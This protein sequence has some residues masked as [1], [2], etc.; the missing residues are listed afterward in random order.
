MP[1]GYIESPMWV[2]TGTSLQARKLLADSN[3]EIVIASKLE[4][5]RIKIATWQKVIDEDPIT[6]EGIKN[7]HD[8]LKG[9]IHSLYQ[10]A[11]Y[12]R[13]T[14]KL[15]YDII[16]LVALID[17]VK[18]AADR[19]I[20]NENRIANTKV[21]STEHNSNTVIND[22]NERVSE[23]G[24]VPSDNNSPITASGHS[25]FETLTDLV[26]QNGFGNLTAALQA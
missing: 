15:S 4:N 1:E 11:L 10:E 9:A 25:G 6:F 12:A 26:T 8:E 2:G 14:D 24:L 7:N 21:L 23:L 18:W 20:R 13:V 17:H 19:Y 22:I 3:Q 5:I 16:G